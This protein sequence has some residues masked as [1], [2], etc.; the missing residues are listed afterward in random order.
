MPSRGAMSPTA[1]ERP[2]QQPSWPNEQGAPTVRFGEVVHDRKHHASV[3][4]GWSPGVVVDD[5]RK[6]VLGN[7]E[8]GVGCAHRE[9]GHA[10]HVV[11]YAARREGNGRR[12]SAPDAPFGV[13]YLPL[14]VALT[15]QPSC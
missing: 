6:S 7:I 5:G 10:I 15:M 13:G 4:G 12:G 2:I 14:C 11:G 9:D 8:L 1:P 3:W